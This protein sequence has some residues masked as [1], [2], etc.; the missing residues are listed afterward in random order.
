MSFLIDLNCDM[1]EGMP[2]DAQL[3]PLIT[4]ANIACGY[5]AGDETT[6]H[7]C[8]EL[9]MKYG[10]LIGVHPSYPD[11][12]NFGRTNMRFSSDEVYDMVSKQIELLLAVAEQ[13]D[14]TVHH[15][16]AHGALY[17]MAAQDKDLA[18]A[19]CRAIKSVKKDLL[20]F[21]LSASPMVQVAKEQGIRCY[22]E[23]FADRSYQPNGTLT[24]RTQPNALLH[25]NEE[26]K[27]QALAMILQ[28]QVKAVDGTIIPIVADTICLH[29]DGNH[30]VE[31]AEIIQQTLKENN[32][33][34]R[35]YS[36]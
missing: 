8:V 13:H 4:S 28:K 6:M 3:M 12:A 29:G 24:P 18:L 17:N 7:R 22:Q 11:R 27:K 26:V 20:L 36:Y 10:V 1:G 9:A 15:I 2:N 19:I 21:A 23:V 25:D 16:K 5:H 33:E 32:I 35:G 14:A 34:I 31:F 30:A